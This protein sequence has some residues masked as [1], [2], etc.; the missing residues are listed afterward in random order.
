[1]APPHWKPVSRRHDARGKRE[2]LI[3]NNTIHRAVFF[4]IGRIRRRQGKTFT[5]DIALEAAQDERRGF[6]Q[7]GDNRHRPIRSA[8]LQLS[9]GIPNAEA[10]YGIEVLIVGYKLRA[11]F[12]GRAS[13]PDVV[14]WNWTAVPLQKIHQLTVYFRIVRRG[15]PQFNAWFLQEIVQLE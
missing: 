7:P 5:A 9:Q 6:P 11:G 4:P 3:S 13:D 14:D 1:M 10:G 15:Q 12:D 8:G 2:Q